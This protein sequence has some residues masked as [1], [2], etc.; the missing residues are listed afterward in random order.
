M[1]S[2]DGRPITLP[3]A[4]SSLVFPCDDG[5]VSMTIKRSARS[6]ETNGAANGNAMESRRVDE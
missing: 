3:A 1:S 2:S 6:R 5:P 4:I